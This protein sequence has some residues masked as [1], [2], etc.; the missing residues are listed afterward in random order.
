MFGKTAFKTPSGFLSP[1]NRVFQKSFES[2]FSPPS[3]LHW[4]LLLDNDFWHRDSSDLGIDWGWRFF[5][6]G[7]DS[8]VLGI[9]EASIGK[10]FFNCDS[11]LIPIL[12][13]GSILGLLGLGFLISRSIL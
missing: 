1:R 8:S 3:H 13:L 2:D 9:D 4:L 7:I 5:I 10:D 12:I 6:L 11:I